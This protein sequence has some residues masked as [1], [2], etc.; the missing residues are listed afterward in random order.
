[1]KIE[2]N[3]KRLICDNFK[4]GYLDE[5]GDSGKKGSKNLVLT[6]ICTD[7]NK[8][9]AKVM[10]KARDGLKRTKKGL[11]WLNKHGEI[12][13][14][15]F[16]DDHLRRKIIGNLSKLDIQIRFIAIEKNKKQIPAREKAGILKDLIVAHVSEEECIPHKIVADKDYFDNKKVA[17]FIVRDFKEKEYSDKEGK[18][19]NGFFCRLEL[20]EKDIFNKENNYDLIVKIKHENSR[21]NSVLQALDLICGSIFQEIEHGDK[22]YTEII[23]K[24]NKNIKGMIRQIN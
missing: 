20:I 5:S 8:K 21:Q 17:Y 19:M 13:F 11:R 2:E 18:I 9:I 22:I 3:K 16:P 12:K 1:M 7:D 24:Y 10:K 15:G 14:S 4:T 6:Y 23:K